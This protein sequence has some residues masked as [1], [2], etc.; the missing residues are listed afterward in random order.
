[1]NEGPTIDTTKVLPLSSSKMNT[2]GYCW[3][4]TSGIHLNFELLEAPKGPE[5]PEAATYVPSLFG[6][7][8]LNDPFAELITKNM[9][10]LVG[11][12]TCNSNQRLS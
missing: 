7:K 6:T 3:Q 2:I 9:H 8:L 11:E 4:L 5:L 12:V 1:M 10:R